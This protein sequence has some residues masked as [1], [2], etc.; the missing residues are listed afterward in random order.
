MLNKIIF[1]RTTSKKC[2]QKSFHE[3][4]LAC[5]HSCMCTKEKNGSPAHSFAKLQNW[6][7]STHNST[8]VGGSKIHSYPTALTNKSQISIFA[9]AMHL[10]SHSIVSVPCPQLPHIFDV[11]FLLSTTAQ[12]YSH[13]N[14]L[15]LSLKSTFKRFQSI[16]RRIISNF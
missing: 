12:L 8:H 2:K 13:C 5:I 7:F 10:I 9:H 4:D 6:K 16:C 14:S 1:K 11:L 15:I 3:G